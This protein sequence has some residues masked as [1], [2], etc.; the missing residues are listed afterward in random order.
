MDSAPKITVLQNQKGMMIVYAAVLMVMI[1]GFLGLALDSSHLFK[2][3]GELQNAADAS[4]LKGSYFLYTRPTDPTVMAS[5]QWDVALAKAREII[6]EHSSDNQALADAVVE[7]GYW[8]M[9]WDPATTHA[10]LPTT[11]AVAGLTNNDIPA[12]KVSVSRASGSNGGA[13]NNFF[14]QL[15]NTSNVPVGSKPAVAV[16]GYPGVVPPGDLF[17]LAISQCMT[18]QY[19]NQV[20]LPDPP[21]TIKMGISA[22]AYPAGG[23]T[24]YTGQWTSFKDTSGGA[25]ST[26]GIRALIAS[27]NPDGL[28]VGDS[29]NIA[30]GTKATLYSVSQA[31]WLPAGGKDVILAVVDSGTSNFTS[32]ILMPITG[33]ATFHIDSM[34]NGSE[35]Y[36]YG[37]FINFFTTPVGARPGGPPSNTVTLPLMVQ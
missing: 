34:N 20:P 29:I 10:L 12:V 4:A 23:A 1:L 36:I 33:F 30:A 18:S 21:P 27:G 19:F 11:T 3:R 8:D 7:V 25:D 24:C 26:T 22:Y 37:H 31:D 32:N 9:T 17:P 5:L 6:K 14:M 15:L 2:V 35:K 13:V 28:A 16:S